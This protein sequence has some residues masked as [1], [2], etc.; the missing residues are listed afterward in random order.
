MEV[1]DAKNL[2]PKDREGLVSPF[3]KP[4]FDGQCKRTKMK[5]KDLN[6]NWNEKL[7]FTV[8]DPSTM[9]HEELEIEVFNDKETCTS[10]RHNFLGRVKLP[11][12]LH[13]KKHHRLN[14]LHLQ[15]IRL[16]K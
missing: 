9:I 16:L 13:Q 15:K 10:R 2:M 4:S 11:G 8:S 3:V 6:P 7:E 14:R 5:Y 12:E 1:V